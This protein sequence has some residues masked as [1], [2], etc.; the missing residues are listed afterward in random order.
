MRSFEELLSDSG[1]TD[2]DLNGVE[3]TE[4]EVEER[5]Q[6]FLNGWRI[7]EKVYRKKINNISFELNRK[8]LQGCR[9]E[10]LILFYN[11]RIGG[12]LNDFI[13]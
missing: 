7:A 4:Y 3:I 12:L 10:I 13:F 8:L 9:S 1:L 11:E 6:C 2:L 5:A